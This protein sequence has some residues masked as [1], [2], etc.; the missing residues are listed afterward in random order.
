MKVYLIIPLV[1]IS[2]FG[3]VNT[4]IASTTENV[5]SLPANQV[6]GYICYQDGS[7]KKITAQSAIWMAK[8]IDGETW[9]HPSRADATSMLW[10]IVQRTVL[11]SWRHKKLHKKIQQYSQPI[12]PRWT[13]NGDKCRKYYSRGYAGK[14]PRNCSQ[15]RVN[16]RAN[17]IRK[18]WKD[19]ALL[20]RKTVIDFIEGSI[21]NPVI[22]AI[23][24]YA[25]KLWERRERKG[26]NIKARQVFHSQIDGNVYF[27]R[28]RRP[29]TANWKGL[30][31]TV[32]S[33]STMCPMIVK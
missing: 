15:K 14:I 12:N 26:T 9:G 30:E 2:F 1:L 31:V 17:N 18:E 28:N 4:V 11:P 5:D 16:K 8:M 23:G 33:K 22:G 7:E 24:W 29:N 10:S 6:L 27:A 21:R 3:A 25:P 13:K 32:V 19:T 20:A